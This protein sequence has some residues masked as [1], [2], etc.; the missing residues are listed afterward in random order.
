MTQ[1]M[2]N[3]Y[4]LRGA[5][6]E[7]HLLKEHSES[8]Q[9]LLS[10]AYGKHNLE[11][12]Q[13]HDVY[14]YRLNERARLLFAIHDFGTGPSLLI[15]DYLPTHDYHKSRFLRSGVLKNYLSAQKE[16]FAEAEKPQFIRCT[17]A[18]PLPVVKV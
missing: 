1:N 10:G 13:G 7:A 11:R 14:S 3:L 6:G 8:I 17:D 15:L 4:Y 2:P 16:K 12:L 18:T 5:L 9:A